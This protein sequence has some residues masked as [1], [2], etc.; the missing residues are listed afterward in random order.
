MRPMHPRRHVERTRGVDVVHRAT[1]DVVHGGAVDVETARGGEVLLWDD[2]ETLRE[3]GGG[4][5][6]IVV[7]PAVAA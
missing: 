2:D 7:T 1:V 5:P 4:D 6:R 3:A